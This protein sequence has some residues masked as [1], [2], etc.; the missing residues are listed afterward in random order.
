MISD[1]HHTNLL[2]VQKCIIHFSSNKKWLKKIVFFL[3]MTQKNQLLFAQNP[4][5]NEIQSSSFFT[6]RTDL[7][8]EKARLKHIFFY[9]HHHHYT[10]VFLLT[11]WKFLLLIA[12]SWSHKNMN[13][14]LVFVLHFGRNG[15]KQLSGYGL[16]FSIVKYQQSLLT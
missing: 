10:P 2:R 11:T 4:K 13:S 1:N 12:K 3:Q 14:I 6:W 7:H 5:A 16:K 15:P 8:K 9:L